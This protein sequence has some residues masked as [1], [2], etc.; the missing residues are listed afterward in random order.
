MNSVEN[1][2]SEISSIF[3]KYESI[4]NNVTA[5]GVWEGKSC[6]NY[7]IQSSDL[8]S[9]YVGVIESQMSSLNTAVNLLSNYKD[10]KDDIEKRESQLANLNDDN[11]KDGFMRMRLSSE[12]N[13]LKGD[14]ENLKVQIKSLLASISS[15]KLQSS[16]SYVSGDFVYYN[17]KDYKQ[18]YGFGTTIASSGCGPT[19]MA[20]VL[21]S[22][23]GETVD[24]VEAA[25][26]SIKH[27]YR[28]DNEH[29]TWHGYFTSMPEEY[30][31][32]SKEMS[33]SK[34]NI[35]ETLN[36]GS[37][38]IISMGPGHFTSKGHF[39]VL[40]GMT[41]SG[42]VLVADPNSKEKSKEWDINTIV[43]EG[44]KMWGFSN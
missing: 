1:D 25:N 19:S 23:T 30:G 3:N 44:K 40:R 33:V 36:S 22:I 5:P 32:N 43:N 39:I 21:S 9:T 12:I 2:A 29:G 38:I 7:K 11:D 24:P 27:G 31:V 17:Q 13:K 26:W 14:L 34:K 41:E 6:E 37:P 4:S 35:E 42:K 15:Q 20:M 10:I 8:I 28:T 16:S 18:S